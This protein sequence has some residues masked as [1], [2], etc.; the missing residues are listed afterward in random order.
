MEYCVNSN[1]AIEFKKRRPTLTLPQKEHRFAFDNEARYYIKKKGTGF[2][3]GN[4]LAFQKLYNIVCVSLCHSF[5]CNPYSVYNPYAIADRLSC[6]YQTFVA[7]KMII[8]VSIGYEARFIGFYEPVYSSQIGLHF[9][10][11]K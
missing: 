10:F 2:Y 9:G 11:V 1:S 3:F 4:A 8:G 6:G 7:D 5:D